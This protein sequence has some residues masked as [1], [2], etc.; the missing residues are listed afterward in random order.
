MSAE[1]IQAMRQNGLQILEPGND[2]VQAWQK[3]TAAAYPTIRGGMVSARD[4]D[5]AVRLTA[6]YRHRNGATT[7]R[8]AAASGAR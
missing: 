1:A 2:A 6:E 3:K 7:P 4:F 8:P 5:D